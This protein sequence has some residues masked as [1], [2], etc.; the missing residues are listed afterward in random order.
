[1]AVANTKSTDVT[2]KD[3]AP[4]VLSAGIYGGY[5]TEEN[6]NNVAVAAADDDT[7]V[8]RVTRLRSSDIIPS[9]QVMN[10]AITSGTDYDLGIYQTA[11]NGGAVVDADLIADGVDMSSARVVWTEVRYNDTATAKIEEFYK[12]LWQLLGLTSD[13]MREYDLCWTANTVGSAAGDIVTRVVRKA[14]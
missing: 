1:M 4:Q 7:S 14:A 9:I 2:N 8:Y 13:P 10:D 12:P 11:A 6:I 3:A 5:R